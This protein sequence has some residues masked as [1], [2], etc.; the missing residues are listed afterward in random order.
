MSSVLT[1][2]YMTMPMMSLVMLM[3]GPVARAGSIFSF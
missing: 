2:V 3:N 1:V